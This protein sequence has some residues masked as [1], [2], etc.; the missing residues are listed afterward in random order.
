[1]KST[2]RSSQPCVDMSKLWYFAQNN[3]Q[4]IDRSIS[5]MKQQS[6]ATN[7]IRQTKFLTFLDSW[8]TNTPS[9]KML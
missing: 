8:V 6:V 9:I 3:I 4:H 7:S 5:L 2:I 1:M